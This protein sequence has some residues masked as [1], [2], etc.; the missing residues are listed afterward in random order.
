MSTL[1]KTLRIAE[2]NSYRKPRPITLPRVGEK[3]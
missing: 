2:L 1:I 3:Q